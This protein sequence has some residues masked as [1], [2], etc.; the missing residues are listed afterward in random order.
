[1]G[2]AQV[3]VVESSTSCESV[4]VELNGGVRVSLPVGADPV[5]VG[6]LLQSVRQG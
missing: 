2:F 1:M 4:L 5:W 3:N 6:R